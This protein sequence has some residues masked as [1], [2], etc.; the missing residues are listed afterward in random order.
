MNWFKCL[1]QKIMGYLDKQ[2]CDC[3][4]MLHSMFHLYKRNLKDEE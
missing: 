4:Y 3:V 1:L 2:H